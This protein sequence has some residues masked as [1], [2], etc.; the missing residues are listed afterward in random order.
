[1]LVSLALAACSGHTIH[2]FEVDI[3]S[4]IP[5]SQRQGELDLATAQIRFPDDPAGQLLE[6]PAAEALVDGRLEI[7]LIVKNTGTLDS[8]LSLE[9]RL[10]PKD[11]TDLYDGQGGDFSAVQQTVSLAPGEEKT[12][13]L[14][15]DVN[16]NTPAFN[17]IQSG[18]FR[19]GARLSL[20]GERVQ[21]TLTRAELMLRL[22]LF[23]LIPNP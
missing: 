11:D 4:F 17:L 19:V 5:Q 18:Q 23:N 15:L 7:S 1:M 12:V 20:S 10:G 14:T 21:Y 8:N 2:R 9:V 3:L 13:T 6:V 16:P 22:K